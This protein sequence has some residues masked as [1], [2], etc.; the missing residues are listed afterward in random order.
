M[1]FRP[2]NNVSV[3]VT[4]HANGTITESVSGAASQVGDVAERLGRGVGYG[5]EKARL[6]AGSGF[7]TAKCSE[8]KRSLSTANQAFYRKFLPS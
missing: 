7:Y 6:E 5:T 2:N 1:T 4:H 8:C 3:S